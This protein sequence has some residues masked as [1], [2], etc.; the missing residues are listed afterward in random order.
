VHIQGILFVAACQWTMGSMFYDPIPYA[1]EQGI[2]LR[3]AG[4]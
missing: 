3:L 4:N 1:S 2:Y